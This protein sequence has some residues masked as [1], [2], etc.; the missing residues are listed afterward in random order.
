LL[1]TSV[2]TLIIHLMHTLV[3]FWRGHNWC[4]SWPE[5]QLSNV[6]AGGKHFKYAVKW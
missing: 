1:T 5:A 3:R 2:T 6:H 4:Y